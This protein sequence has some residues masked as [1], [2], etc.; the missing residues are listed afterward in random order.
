MFSSSMKPIKNAVAFVIYSP[1][2]T[3][4]LAV[5][6]PFN[7]ENLPGIWGLPAGSLKE[8]ESYEEAVLR[9][10]REKLGVQLQIVKPV[11]K[12]KLSEML[13]IFT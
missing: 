8:N 2:G 12:V 6:R 9:A 10:G 11:M 5:Q 1:D 4:I 3:K 13:S 7:D